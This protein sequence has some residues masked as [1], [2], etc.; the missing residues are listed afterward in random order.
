MK[1]TDKNYLELIPTHTAYLKW[2]SDCRGAVTI[3]I[4]NKGVFNRIAQLILKKPRVSHVHLDEK[5]SCVWLL[6]D[7][8]RSIAEVG[9]QLEGKFGENT[10][11]LYEHLAQYMA[12]LHKCGFIKLI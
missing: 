12:M 2:S 6:I 10:A 7:G 8:R 9:R 11:M 1:K 3:D 5:G 4:E